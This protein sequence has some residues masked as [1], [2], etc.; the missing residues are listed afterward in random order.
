M[1]DEHPWWAYIIALLI[2]SFALLGLMDCM[3]DECMEEGGTK[4]QC[5]DEVMWILLL[6]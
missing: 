5:D 2:L 3:H 1:S 4:E 6:S